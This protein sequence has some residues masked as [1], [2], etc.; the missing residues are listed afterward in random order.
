MSERIALR[1]LS[2]EDAKITWK[3]RNQKDIMINYAGHP[4]PVSYEMERA[5]YE[6]MIY[7]NIPTSAFA[8]ELIKSKKIIGMT[9]LKNINFINR[10]AE[11]AIFIGDI[12]ERNKGYAEEATI[13]AQNM[14]FMELGLNR[15]FLK[16]NEDNISAIELYRKCGF[17][18]EGT[19]R[20]CVYKND[21]LKNQYVMSILKREF[22]RRKKVE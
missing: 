20:E 14:A 9:F 19:L 11:F 18:K 16:V 17:K 5:W 12:E 8:I 15:I 3:W 7:S 10:E 6:K 21:L 2:L 1:A 13:L 22:V 4:F